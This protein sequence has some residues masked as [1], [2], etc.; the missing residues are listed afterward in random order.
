M[1]QQDSF[2]LQPARKIKVNKKPDAGYPAKSECAASLIISTL[3]KV[4]VLFL[5]QKLSNF[6]LKSAK[7]RTVGIYIRRESVITIIPLV[8]SCTVPFL[9]FVLCFAVSSDNFLCGS[10][11]SL[12][13]SVRSCEGASAR[14]K[15]PVVS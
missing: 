7:Y 15:V 3:Y 12:F 8:C 14:L 13:S 9:H 2:L 1:Q 6:G 11:G 10:L 5:L 4:F